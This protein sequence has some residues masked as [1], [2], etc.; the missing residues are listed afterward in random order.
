MDAAAAITKNVATLL[1]RVRLL[2][3]RNDDAE[4]VTTWPRCCWAAGAARSS[5]SWTAPSFLFQEKGSEVGQHNAR[6]L[7]ARTRS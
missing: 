2:R 7:L 1:A 3:G 5:T 6:R 4:E